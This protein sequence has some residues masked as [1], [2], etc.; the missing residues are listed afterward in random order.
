MGSLSVSGL[1]ACVSP[2]I[3]AMFSVLHVY[4]I[5]CRGCPSTSKNKACM[6]EVINYRSQT[7]LFFLVA[8][9]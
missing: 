3:T 6:V 9:Y 7:C 5:V 1:C 8:T 2:V 4:C